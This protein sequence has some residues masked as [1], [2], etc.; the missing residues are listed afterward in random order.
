MKEKIKASPRKVIY[1]SGPMTGMPRED[2]MAIFHKAEMLLGAAGFHTVNPTRFAPCR[3]PWMFKIL[4]YRITLLYDLW[5]LSKCQ[6]I[7]KMPGWRESKG[8][9]I[10][11]CWAF[12]FGMWTLPTKMRE[13][14]DKK[15]CK[16]IERL[17]NDRK[18]KKDL[19]Q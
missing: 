9:Q 8:A 14:I 1:I 10:E 3:W 6:F 16:Y 15:M 2:Y 17:K 18:Q 5:Q 13:T 7:Y 11:S 19:I 4:G 12:H